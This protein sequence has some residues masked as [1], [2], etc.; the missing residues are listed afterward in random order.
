MTD[1][2]KITKEKLEKFISDSSVEL[3]LAEVEALMDAEVE[4]PEAEMDTELVDM[5][6]AILAKA[7]NPGFEEGKPA[8]MYRPWEDE[9]APA[10]ENTANAK[11]DKK[12]P[13]SFRRTVLVVAAVLVILFVV[14]L[15]AGARLFVDGAPDGIVQF[16][17]RVFKINL[18]KDEPTTVDENDLV[19]QMILDSLDTLMLP[20]VLLS[21]EYEKEVLVEQ[22][23][24]VTIIRVDVNNAEQ[25]ISGL[26]TIT[27]YKSADHN[28]TNGQVN[29]SD[30]HTN[31][32]QLTIDGKDII[33]FGMGE[34][35]YINYSDGAT[36]YEIALTCDFDKMVSIAETINVKG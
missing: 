21:N 19:N 15:P 24:F 26:I 28:M 31:Y 22:K 30:E 17:S 13:V 18:N 34:R 11:N 8:Q 35:S 10:T 32:K 23:E 4:K 3:D 2:V 25:D 6:A 12:K 9:E 20:E 29:V 7:Y 5:C 27:Q 16:C 33:V 36:N 14:A 1:N